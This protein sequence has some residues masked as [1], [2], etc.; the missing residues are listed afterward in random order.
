MTPCTGTL[1]WSMTITDGLLARYWDSTCPVCGSR[2]RIVVPDRP[3]GSARVVPGSACPNE[4]ADA[5]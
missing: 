5:A 1:A 4:F 2:V 3:Q